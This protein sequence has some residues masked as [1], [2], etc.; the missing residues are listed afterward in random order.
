M[1]YL[2]LCIIY[3]YFLYIYFIFLLPNFNIDSFAFCGASN[4]NCHIIFISIFLFKWYELCPVHYICICVCS[5]AWVCVN[6]YI[7]ISQSVTISCQCT[8][9][10]TLAEFIDNFSWF[11]STYSFSLRSLYI[12]SHFLIFSLSLFPLSTLASLQMRAAG[13]RRMKLMMMMMKLLA[14]RL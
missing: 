11:F 2:L 13:H 10:D 12:F 3:I 1:L 14:G 7:F 9:M 4:L 8:D 6:Q 5:C